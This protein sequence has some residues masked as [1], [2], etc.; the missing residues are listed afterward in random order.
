MLWCL[1]F[2]LKYPNNNKKYKA[3][4]KPTKS[5][6]EQMEKDGKKN[7]SK[8]MLCTRGLILVLSSFGYIL[9]FYKKLG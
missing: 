6:I 9:N 8:Q 5:S 2:A 7:Y 4:L 3:K 1:G